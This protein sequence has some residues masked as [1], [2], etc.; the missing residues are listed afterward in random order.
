MEYLIENIIIRFGVPFTLFIN[1]IPNI[2]GKDLKL[3]LRSFIL[4]KRFIILII[5]KE[6][7]KMKLIIR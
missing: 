5:S 1:N 7:A 2:R 4:R 6:M 3:F